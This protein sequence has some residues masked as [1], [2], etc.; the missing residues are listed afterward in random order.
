M[1]VRW[2][3]SPFLRSLLGVIQMFFPWFASCITLHPDFFAR[4][5]WRPGA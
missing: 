4:S 5:L 3:R 1:V 2:V